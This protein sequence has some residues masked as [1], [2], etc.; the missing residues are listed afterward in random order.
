MNKNPSS[1]R[2]PVVTKLS[3]EE[4]PEIMQMH[5]KQYEPSASTTQTYQ[6]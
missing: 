3:S 6:F 5:V 4:L 2:D 1:R